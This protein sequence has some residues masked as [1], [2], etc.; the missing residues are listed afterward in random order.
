MDKTAGPSERV[1]LFKLRWLIY[2]ENNILL[3]FMFN[4]FAH[5]L[6]VGTWGFKTMPNWQ[7]AFLQYSITLTDVGY[8]VIC[9]KPIVVIRFI[10]EIKHRFNFISS[11]FKYPHHLLQYEL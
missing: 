9:M 10:V 8:Q 5:F 1:N 4:E 6:I 11:W 7:T 3:H 2:K